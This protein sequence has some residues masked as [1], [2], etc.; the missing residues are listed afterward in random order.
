[1]TLLDT[2]FTLGMSGQEWPQ[3]WFGSFH[4][5]LQGLLGY[6]LSGWA[7]GETFENALPQRK[8]NTS[9]DKGPKAYSDFWETVQ[10]EHC[11]VRLIKV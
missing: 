7:A 10:G 8:T 5:T 1:M 6:Q 3:L 9:D 11:N 2:E 4:D